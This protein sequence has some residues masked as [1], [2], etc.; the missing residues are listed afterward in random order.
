M[1]RATL[2]DTRAA[3]LAA[4]ERLVRQRARE[5]SAAVD[6]ALG[7]LKAGDVAAEAGLSKGMIYHLWPSQEEYRRDLLLH[8]ARATTTESYVATEP[9]SVVTDYDDAD[10]AIAGIASVT[11]DRALADEQ[12][13]MFMEVSSFVANDAV[14]HEMAG[15][16][17]D[18]LEATARFFE[19]GLAI[20]GR[21]LR[22]GYSA[23]DLVLLT[24]AYSRG[25]TLQ[26]KVDGGSLFDERPWRGARPRTLYEIGVLALFDALTETV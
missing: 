4:G 7:H 23:E 10:D 5:R 3:L 19:A 14:R 1:P 13:F 16:Q 25:V 21:R 8:L 12:W 20:W 22:D 24:R 18:A 26:A 2:D 11:L 9:T 17:S 6:G 15:G